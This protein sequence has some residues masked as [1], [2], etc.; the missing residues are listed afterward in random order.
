MIGGKNF[1]RVY[2]AN[3]QTIVRILRNFGRNLGTLSRFWQRTAAQRVVVIASRQ[4]SID[5]GITHEH[6]PSRY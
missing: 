2:L 3:A 1:S 5:Q 4:R 6:Q